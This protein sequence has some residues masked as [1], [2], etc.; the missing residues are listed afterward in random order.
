LVLLALTS[1]AAT[2]QV[3]PAAPATFVVQG[4]LLSTAARKAYLTYTV[5]DQLVVESAEVRQGHFRFKL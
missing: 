5:A 1:L 3:K 4:I 2:V